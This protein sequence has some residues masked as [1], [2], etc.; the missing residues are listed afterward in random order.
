M[1]KN[2]DHQVRR[3]VISSAVEEIDPAGLMT[4]ETLSLDDYQVF[5]LNPIDT[6]FSVNGMSFAEGFEGQTLTTNVV[7]QGTFVDAF[8]V[9]SGTP[10]DPLTLR[11]GTPNSNLGIGWTSLFGMSECSDGI[12]GNCSGPELDGAVSAIFDT[13]QSKVGFTAAFGA[14]FQIQFFKSDGSLLDSMNIINPPQAFRDFAFQATSGQEE[15]AGY[16]LTTSDLSGSLY[17]DFIF[18]SGVPK[19]V[20]L[21]Q[22]VEVTAD[23]RT[24]VCV[25][26]EAVNDGS[27]DPQELRWLSSQ[28]AIVVPC[29]SLVQVIIL[30]PSRQLTLTESMKLVTLQSLSFKNAGRVSTASPTEMGFFVAVISQRTH[31]RSAPRTSIAASGATTSC[32]SAQRI[33]SALVARS[34]HSANSRFNYKCR[35]N[36][37][38]F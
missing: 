7:D 38:A 23:V 32:L 27:Y 25:A 34:M 24:E 31:A 16:S 2:L 29:V 18:C 35:L 30:S 22:D 20:A 28:L 19:P 14:T 4:C 1:G 3:K 10:T 21:C 12:P 6:A 37:C 9:L 17:N 13:P 8:D 15:I 5:G 36:N 11:L 26:T 33:M